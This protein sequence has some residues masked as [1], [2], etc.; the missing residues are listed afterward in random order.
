MYMKKILFVIDSLDIGGIQRTLI[1]LLKYFSRFDD[2]DI[3]LLSLVNEGELVSEVPRNIRRIEIDLSKQKFLK[4]LR[5][6]F[7]KFN[8]LF[9]LSIFKYIK[10]N[11]NMQFGE[12]IRLNVINSLDEIDELYD[13]AI[14]YSDSSSLFFVCQKVNALRKIVWVHMEY[15]LSNNRP[16]YHSEFYE[17]MDKIVCVSKNSM[18]VFCKLNPE[19]KAKTLVIH[20]LLDTEMIDTLSK[21][22]C[23]EFDKNFFN[24]VSVGRLSKE[25]NFEK[26]IISFSKVLKIINKKVRLYIIG[27]GPEYHNLK[28]IIKEQKIGN[29]CFLLGNKANPYK[30]MKSCD[31]YA[32]VSIKEGFGMTLYEAFYLRKPILSTNVSITDELFK[33]NYDSILVNN[34]I[35]SI[36]DN[37][38]MIIENDK[39]RKKIVNNIKSDII[40]KDRKKYV[41]LMNGENNEEF[42]ED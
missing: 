12:S 5:A 25:K 15:S 31:L 13:I 8:I 41:D 36:T 26:L 30:Y 17:K 6:E 34:S 29:S 22:N 28:K 40:F 38:C 18:K 39:L 24:I 20:N 11:D 16:Q 10:K 19:L 14:A 2:Y 27:D 42:N 35:E 37:L 7:K 21:Q 4:P 3:T 23:N 1:S 32:Q 33:N 9:L